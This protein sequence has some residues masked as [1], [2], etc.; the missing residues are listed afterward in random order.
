MEYDLSALVYIMIAAIFILK[1]CVGSCGG[2]T[3]S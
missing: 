1:F 2:G 3:C